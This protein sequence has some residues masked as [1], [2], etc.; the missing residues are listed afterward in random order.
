MTNPLIQV[1]RTRGDKQ[2]Q[3]RRALFDAAIAVVGEE[4]YAL[5]TVAKLTKRANIANGTF[6]N[7]FKNQQDMFDQLL[8]FVGERLVAHIKA[9]LDPGLTGVTRER[10]R[11]VAYFDFC[12][13]N[14]GFLR[15]LNEAEVF[16]P[17]A[18][19]RH[20]TTLYEGYLGS[21][22]RS[23]EREEITRYDT[24]E[25]GPMVFMLMG[26][27][28]YMTMLYQYKYIER[29]SISIEALADIYEKFVANGLFTSTGVDPPP[30]S[31]LPTRKRVPSEG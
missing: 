26:I 23:V 29:S 18:Y 13:R 2:D 31:A 16:A 30:A 3:T 4:G 21:L 24:E 9:K 25:L 28:S 15:I 1:R 11:F 5:A 17:V 10:A 27:R 7:Y 12:R 14:P 22:L 8:P 19:H 6:Y 20:V